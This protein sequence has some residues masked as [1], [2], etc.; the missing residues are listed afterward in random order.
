MKTNQTSH[1]K[2]AFKSIF[3]FS[4][5]LNMALCAADD[6]KNNTL[7]DTA[8]QSANAVKTPEKSWFGWS[9]SKK[10]SDDKEKENKAKTDQV[11]K[12][13]ET[14]LKK[15]QLNNT[16][17]NKAHGK[18]PEVKV[19]ASNDQAQES[20]DQKKPDGCS[21]N[22]SNGKKDAETQTPLQQ[23]QAEKFAQEKREQ[24]EKL[25]QVEA[26]LAEKTKT[27][28]EEQKR[29]KTELEIRNKLQ[30]EIDA[31][32]KEKE[33]YKAKIEKQDADFKKYQEA[34]QQKQQEAKDREQAERDR[35]RNLTM[36]DVTKGVVHGSQKFQ[37]EAE[38]V[39]TRLS[40]GAQKVQEAVAARVKKIQKEGLVDSVKEQLYCAK[41]KFLQAVAQEEPTGSENDDS[42]GQLVGQNTACGN[43]APTSV[44]ISVNESTRTHE[45]VHNLVAHQ[46][47]LTEVAKESVVASANTNTVRAGTDS[48]PA[49]INTPDTDSGADNG[50][51]P[52]GKPKNEHVKLE[53]ESM[54]LTMLSLAS[55]GIV[56]VT[57]VAY[58]AY[59]YW[60]IAHADAAKL[61]KSVLAQATQQDC[62]HA[63]VKIASWADI[64][65][66][67]GVKATLTTA[68][69][70]KLI[71]KIN[72][73]KTVKNKKLLYVTMLLMFELPKKDTQKIV[74]KL[75]LL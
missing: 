38:R 10:P 24:Q 74:A 75:A 73:V 58:K 50:M 68:Q 14:N 51:H 18:T 17:N 15:E 8:N 3:V 63:V 6:E 31:V 5:F 30:Q 65:L 52:L 27:L 70:E 19:P 41:D 39:A 72:A 43:N 64:T 16:S 62:T 56:G 37:K 25:I 28:E 49:K 1:Y 7:H 66:K 36:S 26:S 11:G 35:Y 40:Q 47:E 2:N 69:F 46:Q 23:E 71:T 33:S 53:A 21:L 29:L 57:V 55:V 61:I 13:S 9:S 20:V 48:V 45:P 60:L 44:A 34:E 22:Q 67:D 12:Q 59:Q 54:N 4:L 32:T 42:K